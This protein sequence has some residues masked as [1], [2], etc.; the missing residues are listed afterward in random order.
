M[1]GYLEPHI[2]ENAMTVSRHAS[3][4]AIGCQLHADHL[5]ILTKPLP[6]KLKKLV[7][8]LAALESNKRGSPERSLEVAIGYRAAGTIARWYRGQT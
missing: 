8:Q 3:L 2:R 4:T 1:G 7:A 5:A 6:R